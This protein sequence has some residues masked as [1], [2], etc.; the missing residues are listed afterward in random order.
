MKKE[1]ELR[2]LADLIDYDYTGSKT[3]P[4]MSRADRAAQF[5]PFAALKGFEQ[6]IEHSER[7]TVEAD[8][9]DEH[10][11]AAIDRTLREL[12][13]RVPVPVRMRLFVPDESREG[14]VFRDFE[15]RLT[16]YD[17]IARELQFEGQGTVELHHLYAIEERSDQDQEE[18][19]R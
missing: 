15:D 2:D 16:G 5:S 14:G 13:T 4:R 6:A 1:K 7:I 11:L 18:R 9:L 17:P 3:R 12:L 8:R 19:D 10:E